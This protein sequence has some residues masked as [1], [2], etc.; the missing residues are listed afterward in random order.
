[1]ERRVTTE[2]DELLNAGAFV[3]SYTHSLDGKKRVTVPSDWREA[4]GNPELYVL[5]GVNEKCLY[6]VTAREM[7]Q[8]LEK[9]RAASVANVKAQKFIRDFFSR[10]DRV[11]LDSQGRIRV[12]DELLAYAG[13][14]NQT[15]MVGAGGRFELWSPESWNEQNSQLD[16]STFAEAAQ[17]IGF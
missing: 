9:V 12:K 11:G 2:M 14:I 4:A 17:Y 13:I 8:R 10:A 3:G 7:T 5:P 1:M 16:Q 15:V 6:V